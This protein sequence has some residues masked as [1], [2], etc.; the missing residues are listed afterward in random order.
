MT[1]AGATQFLLTTEKTF[2]HY[3]TYKNICM[4]LNAKQRTHCSSVKNRNSVRVSQESVLK[5][6]A[7]L[8]FLT[9]FLLLEKR[10]YQVL[11]VSSS[12]VKPT[13]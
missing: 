3:C 5:S 8:K 4:Y 10:C 7:P 6:L 12:E 11:A 9:E 1:D 2:V 13:K